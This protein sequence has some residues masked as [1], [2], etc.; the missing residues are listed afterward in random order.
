MYNIFP[1]L[2]K[3]VMKENTLEL[4]HITAYFS[5]KME[6]VKKE[7]ETFL[8]FDCAKENA[9]LEF[10]LKKNLN[11]EAY[12]IDIEED[13]IKVYA[14]TNNGFFYACKTLKQ[15][16]T[17]LPISLQCAHIEDEPDLEVRGFMYDIS[18]N[19]VAKLS[20]LEYIVDIMADLK[21]NHLE[22]Y[23]EGFSFEYKSFP[24]YLTKNAYISVKEY[25]KLE[26]Y[27]LDRCIDLVPNQNGF[28]H[29]TDWLAQDELKDLAV[30]P[31]GMYLWGSHRNP[32]TLDP[33]DDRSVELVAKMYDD[34]LPI[35]KSKYFNMNFD[36]PFELGKGKSEA[37]ANEIGIDELYI[38]YVNKVYPHIKKYNKQPMIW[39]DVLVRHGASLENMPKDMIYLDWGYEGDYPFDLHLKKLKDANVPFISAPGTTTWCSWLGRLYDWVENISNAI[40]NV[41]KLG[42]MGVLTTDW[43]DFGHLQH[44]LPTLPPLVFTGLLSYRCKAGTIKQVRNYLNRFVFKDKNNLFADIVMD[45]GSYYQFEKNWRGNGT[46][47]YATFSFM[48]YAMREEDHMAKF[49][50]LMRWSQLDYNNYLVLLDFF[51]TKKKQVM[52]ADVDKVW[53]DE[54]NHTIDLITSI[55]HVNVALLDRFSNA[56]KI[57]LLEKAKKGLSKSKKTLKKIWLNR[58]K[59]SYLDKTYAYYDNAV[60]FIDFFI[61]ELQGGTNEAKN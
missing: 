33:S 19:K 43:G 38:E 41:Y 60:D 21:M 14:S 25:K 58:N 59:Y 17:Y 26:K 45:A 36:E 55:Y 48:S 18:R 52:L 16:L 46:V 30:L 5:K 61:K 56:E 13:G 15:I 49:K 39:G 37:R 27:C 11:K 7:M 44:L 42:G 35:S 57:E 54:I 10:L 34:M 28:G 23:V 31:G 2:K 9:N 22:L 53:K 20:T 4:D 1:N 24:Q 40:W 51:K 29:M 3:Q 47:A 50:E 32:S 6:N 8:V 12:E